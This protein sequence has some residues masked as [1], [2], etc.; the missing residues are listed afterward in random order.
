M[1]Y[2]H[3]Q[4]M[5]FLHKLNF[6]LTHPLSGQAVE[7]LYSRSGYAAEMIGAYIEHI[8]RTYLLRLVFK[9]ENSFKRFVI[10]VGRMITP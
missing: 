5:H 9:A 2:H 3:W 1:F 7:N 4:Y 8:V 10:R 6:Y